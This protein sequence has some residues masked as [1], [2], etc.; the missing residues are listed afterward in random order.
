MTANVF[1]EDI[2]RCI[3]AGMNAH[4]GKPLDFNEVMAVL[5]K[6]LGRPGPV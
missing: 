1:K 4:V 6:Y 3:E 5:G 2:D